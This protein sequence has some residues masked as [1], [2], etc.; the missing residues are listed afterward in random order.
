MRLLRGESDAITVIDGYVYLSAFPIVDAAL[1]S[2]TAR[3]AARASTA[4]S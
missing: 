1:D 2:V 4:A 3:R